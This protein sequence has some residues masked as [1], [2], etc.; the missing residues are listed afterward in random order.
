MYLFIKD[1]RQYRWENILLLT[2]SGKEDSEWFVSVQNPVTPNRWR[3]G[4]C[5]LGLGEKL[6]HPSDHVKIGLI[7][8]VI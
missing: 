2:L 6:K 8:R 3:A 1:S 7:N 5:V 4:F